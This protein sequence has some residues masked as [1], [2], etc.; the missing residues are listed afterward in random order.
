MLNIARPNEPVFQIDE[1]S[2][3]LNRAALIQ[4]TFLVILIPQLMQFAECQVSHMVSAH[5]NKL[6][7]HCRGVCQ[8]IKSFF[9]S[10]FFTTM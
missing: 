10:S 6:I 9:F 5:L 8:F 1:C 4:Q 7:T 3:S 2:A